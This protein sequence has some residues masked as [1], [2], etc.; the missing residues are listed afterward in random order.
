M[1][2]RKPVLVLEQWVHENEEWDKRFVSKEDISTFEREKLLREIKD[3]INV[4]LSKE[5]FPPVPMFPPMFP[6]LIAG[7]IAVGEVEGAR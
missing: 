7:C 3:G 6:M 4:D 2:D 1:I 5:P